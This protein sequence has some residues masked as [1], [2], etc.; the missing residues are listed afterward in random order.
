MK[1]YT[2]SWFE[3]REASCIDWHRRSHVISDP[4][5]INMFLNFNKELLELIFHKNLIWGL[6]MHVDEPSTPYIPCEETT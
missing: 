4:E 6:Q 3:K 5:L 2:V 1:K